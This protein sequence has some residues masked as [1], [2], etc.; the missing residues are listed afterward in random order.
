MF[1]PLNIDLP[2][3]CLDALRNFSSGRAHALHPGMPFNDTS[4][5]GSGPKTTVKTTVHVT[6]TRHGHPLLD[7]LTWPFRAVG[8]IIAAP[9]ICL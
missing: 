2:R 3:I 8:G 4:G 5:P 9:V 1:D 7:V 6:E